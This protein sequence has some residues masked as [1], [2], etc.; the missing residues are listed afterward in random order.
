MTFDEQEAL[1][2]CLDDIQDT[3][4]VSNC[5]FSKWEIDFIDSILEQW[6]EKKF[7]TP[8]Q[9]MTVIRIWEKI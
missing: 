7:L 2:N 1:Q 5:P 8:K 3:L 9:R 4:T 6:E